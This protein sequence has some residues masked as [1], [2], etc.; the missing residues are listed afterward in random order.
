[1]NHVLNLDYGPFFQKKRLV[2]ENTTENASAE[3][4]V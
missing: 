3:K 1:M 2:V 4:I